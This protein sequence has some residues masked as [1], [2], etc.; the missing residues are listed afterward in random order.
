MLR[1]PVLILCLLGVLAAC[2]PIYEN[3]PPSPSADEIAALRVAFAELGPE[4][5]EAE[6]AR[7]AQIAYFYPLELARRYMIEDAPVVHNM[8]VNRGLKPRGLCYEWADDMEARLAAEGFQTLALHRAIATPSQPFQLE[9]STVIVSRMGDGWRDGLVLDP[10]R[11]GGRLFWA[12]V[13]DDR[14][15]NWRHRQDVFAERRAQR[16]SFAQ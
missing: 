4:V 11:Y 15:Y 7:A 1:L 8:K 14:R 16:M 6:A 9:H 10:W 5:D 13:S 3:G 2:G 12:R